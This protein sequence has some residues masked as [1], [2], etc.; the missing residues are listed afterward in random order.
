[1]YVANPFI[2]MDSPSSQQALFLIP[3]KKHS[4]T[5]RH[6][7]VKS[8][9]VIFKTRPRMVFIDVDNAANRPLP[10]FGIPVGYTEDGRGRRGDGV[11]LYH[12]G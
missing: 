2:L 9:L 6:K 4:Q 8:N 10:C 11:E 7:T 12:F 1:M 5:I 3:P